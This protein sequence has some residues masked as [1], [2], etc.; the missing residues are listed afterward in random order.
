MMRP[1][2]KVE[3]VYLDPTHADFRKS[4]DG[5]AARVELNIKSRGIRPC[6]FRLAQQATQP[7]EDFVFGAQRFPPLAEGP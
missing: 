6:V 1:C 3:K 2:A 4:I 7:R 5:L